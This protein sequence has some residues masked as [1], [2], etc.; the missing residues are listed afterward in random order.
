MIGTHVGFNSGLTQRS[1]IIGPIVARL[2]VGVTIF[3]L[4]SGFLLYRPFA[5]RSVAAGPR[6]SV[7][8]FLWRRALRIFPALWLFGIVT[9]TWITPYPTHPTDYLH[10]LTLTQVY[11]HHDY[12][13][14]LTQ[15]W[16]LT[17][18]VSFYLLI[19]LFAWLV[20]RPTRTPVR[21]V[22]RQLIGLGT[23]ATVALA[24]NVVQGRAHSA[25]S[26]ALLW[27]PPHLDWF[28]LGMFL[29]LLSALPDDLPALTGL[30]TTV[31]AWAG[32][33]R[34]CWTIAGLAFLI[35]TLPVGVPYS[36]APALWWQWTM[37]HYL[38]G[39]AAFFFML[40]L[41]LGTPS[42][43]GLPGRL[44]SSG[45]ARTLAN[46]SYAIYLWHVPVMLLVQ[47]KLGY[48]SFSGHF[49][50]ILVLTVSITTVVAACSWY[51]LERPLLRYGS[52]N[53]RGSSAASTHGS[54]A[55]VTP[56]SAATA[57]ASTQIT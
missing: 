28:A 52:A 51:L 36:L 29:A 27:L 35:A 50:P 37:Q 31:D 53:W 55:P 32:S 22:R 30:R 39:V 57:T 12:D 42:S 5:L 14:N 47:R 54:P 13:P 1:P 34:T 19:P 46:M 26:E 7:G 44:L 24:Y 2:D 56:A 38:F 25:N 16:T 21:A 3:F 17:V 23:L 49:L 10:Y 4:L 15:L 18:E 9:L 41:V 45:V 20:A 11:D 8:R 6:P 43:N 33:L 40:P 48:A